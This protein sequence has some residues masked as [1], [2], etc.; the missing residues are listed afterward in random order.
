MVTS[1]K[2]YFLEAELQTEAPLIRTIEVR[3][4]VYN[5]TD[6]RALME[7]YAFEPIGTHGLYTILV[8]ASDP[9]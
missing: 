8:R 1:N 9:S 3:T 2:R 5:R 4:T 7:S 6:V